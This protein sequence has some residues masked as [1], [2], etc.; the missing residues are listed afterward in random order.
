MTGAA[1]PA[2]PCSQLP[3]RDLGRTTRRRRPAGVPRVGSH[4]SRFAPRRIV[5]LVCAP[6]CAVLALAG[7]KERHDPPRGSHAPA[8]GAEVAAQDDLRAAFPDA[9]GRMSFRGVQQYGQAIAGH[10]AVCGQVN[11]FA[12]SPTLFVPFVSVLTS[13]NGGFSIERYV[14]TDTDSASRVYMAMI[15]YCY[16]DGGPEAGPLHSVM[17]LPPGPNNV[18]AS[19]P[20]AAPAAQPAAPAPQ[21][22]ATAAP[23]GVSGSADAA[24]GAVSDQSPASGSVTMRQNA[25]LHAAPQGASVR[26]VPAGTVLHVFAQAPGGWLE[27]GDAAP[28]G[29]VHE[30]MVQ[31]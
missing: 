15:R 11:P 12:T 4:M 14:G 19:L 10:T 23:S 5:P 29:W 24:A 7:C 25:N 20:S 28:L 30:S 9:H 18:S 31:R 26:V 6:L 3:R 27:V 1:E 17:A 8:S 16:E 21:R 22:A 13:G 2:S